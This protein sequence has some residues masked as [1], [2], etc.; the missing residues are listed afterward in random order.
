MDVEIVALVFRPTATGS[1]MTPRSSRTP[2]FPILSRWSLPLHDGEPPFHAALLKAGLSG[3]TQRFPPR[4]ATATATIK[5]KN[6]SH[7]T[8]A[9]QPWWRGR[10]GRLLMCATFS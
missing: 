6:A 5:V 7:A 1:R 2:M 10:E 4:Q 8:A 9:A 3:T